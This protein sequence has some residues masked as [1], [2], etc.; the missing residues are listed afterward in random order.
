MLS[1]YI[2]NIQFLKKIRPFDF[3]GITSPELLQYQKYFVQTIFK[4]FFFETQCSRV[5]LT[6][7]WQSAGYK[8][9]QFRWDADTD[10]VSVALHAVI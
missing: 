4:F 9:H 7:R 3:F 1:G 10:I 2:S 5:L 8:T 6:K